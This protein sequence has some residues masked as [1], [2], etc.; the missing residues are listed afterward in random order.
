MR[1]RGPVFLISWC[2][3]LRPT[4]PNCARC[5][6]GVRVAATAGL[7]RV[8]VAPARGATGQPGSSQSSSS[9][10][11]VRTAHKKVRARGLYLILIR[12]AP[13]LRILD[14]RQWTDAVCPGCAVNVQPLPARALPCGNPNAPLQRAQFEGCRRLLHQEIEEDRRDASFSSPGSTGLSRF[15]AKNSSHQ[16]SNRFHSSRRLATG[17]SAAGIARQPLL[18]H[19]LMQA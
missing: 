9:R 19:I 18:R 8:E 13:L 6:G 12:R 2:S 3:N 11:S 10:A 16:R 4:L 14:P 1:R 17:W 7:E 15:C 5:K